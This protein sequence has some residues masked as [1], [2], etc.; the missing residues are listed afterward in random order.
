MILYLIKSVKLEPYDVTTMYAYAQGGSQGPPHY[1]SPPTY[2]MSP[3]HHHQLAA[4]MPLATSGLG[5]A[6][7]MPTVDQTAQHMT[8]HHTGLHHLEPQ[9]TE[10][11]A[12]SKR[13]RL[14]YFV[15]NY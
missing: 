5:T 4:S 9:L 8:V 7:G 11:T 13:R 1:A 6:A 10:L 14:V 12:Q 15:F 2:H 3:H